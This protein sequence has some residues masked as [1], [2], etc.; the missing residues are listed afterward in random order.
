MKQ[1][2]DVTD[3]RYIFGGNTGMTAEG[4]A[5]RRKIADAMMSRKGAPKNVGEGM[6]AASRAIMGALLARH[7]EKQGAANAA[8]SQA[9]AN[10]QMMGTEGF[11]SEFDEF[12]GGGGGGAGGYGG[13][14]YG[15]VEY[16]GAGPVQGGAAVDEYMRQNRPGGQP[17]L[18]FGEVP[19]SDVPPS[20][21][22]PN[23]QPMA[24][25]P[26]GSDTV[27]GSMGD[28]M[29]MADDP[30]ATNALT[31]GALMPEGGAM[32]QPAQSPAAG[33]AAGAGGNSNPGNVYAGTR[34]PHS[35]MFAR[36]EIQAGLPAGYLGTT[37]FIESRFN[38]NANNPE[39]SA[40]GPFQFINSTAR[41]YGLRNKY[42][43][44]QATD[45]AT[46]LA[47]DNASVLRRALGRNPTGAELYLAH[48]QGS[49]GAAKLLA[50]PNARAVDIVGRDAVRLN[51][52]NANMT[53]QQF[54]NL[55]LKKYDREAARLGLGGGAP[56]APRQID[57]GGF[58]AGAAGAVGFAGSPGQDTIMGQQGSDVL[59]G[60]EDAGGLSF[61]TLA[62]APQAA[63][64]PQQPGM[65][66]QL[67]M[68]QPQPMQGMPELPDYYRPARSTQQIFA[69]LQDWR[70]RGIILSPE[71]KQIVTQELEKAQRWE[72][73][74]QRAQLRRQ[75]AEAIGWQPQAPQADPSRFMLTD[76]QE[77]QFGLDPRG[78]YSWKPDG[79]FNVLQAPPE[80]QEPADRPMKQDANGRWRYTDGS[81][82]L[83][84]PD[85][86]EA[87]NGGDMTESERRIF[88]FNSMQQQTGP[89]IN[90]LEEYGFNPSN[91]QD[92]LA[93][94]VLGGNYFATPEGQMYD[95]AAGAWAESA[96][97]LA[98][99]AAATPEEYAR[100][101][102]MYFASAGD[103]PATIAFKR[104]MR[105]SYEAVLTATLRG[106][107]NADVPKPLI[108]AVEAYIAQQQGGQPP[109]QPA[110][111]AQPQSA[112][113]PPT[114]P[115]TT[116]PSPPPPA[117][118]PAQAAPPN[119]S[120]QFMV[121]TPDQVRSMTPVQRARMVAA[122]GLENVPDEILDVLEEIAK[123]EQ[124]GNP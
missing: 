80:A 61:G 116:P 119:Q 39:S 105:A 50:S 51:G 30:Q 82:E 9:A 10:A 20:F 54:A 99:G 110:P 8:A 16:G 67:G 93:R 112:P 44:G 29:L 56:A 26:T 53:A 120:E 12:F 123:G 74:I 46:R 18:G 97:R 49:A 66:Q 84:F 3:K 27:T 114:P 109:G 47:S 42:D 104:Q 103:D 101:R 55:W 113:Q 17:A 35:D 21:M 76:D 115:A 78:V 86:D 24:V 121:P 38:P 22:M 23:G 15:G 34:V 59:S 31:F 36:Y 77:R 72:D 2:Q 96:L 83:V 41:Q 81:K 90:M 19:A 62:T 57:L 75:H 68:S 13:V 45:A 124:N 94:G 28:D 108:F 117:S 111:P 122:I 107:I 63:P 60:G 4:V 98:T 79:T 100:I 64:Q 95:A 91:I 5:Q 70:R 11:G 48:Q 71:Q 6:D 14:N 32:P 85:V 65:P 92:K 43:W 25:A 106:D 118:A 1:M 37:A 52:G 102:D 33:P 87:S 88:M 7:A 40:G 58:N 73:P 89:A 69:Q